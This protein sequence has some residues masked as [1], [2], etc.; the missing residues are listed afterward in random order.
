MQLIASSMHILIAILIFGFL[1]FIHEFGHYAVAKLCD[2]KVDEFSIGMGPKLFGFTKGETLYA[3][4]LVPFG[5]YVKMDGEEDISN[6]ERAFCNKK[7]WQRFLVCIAGV[8]MNVFLGFILVLS[9]VASSDKLTDMTVVKFDDGAVSIKSGLQEGDKILEI[10]NHKLN[11]RKD[12]NYVLMATSNDENINMLVKRNNSLITLR[13]V[14]LPVVQEINGIKIRDFDFEFGS[15]EK[16]V[17]GVL[18]YTCHSIFSDVKSVYI[19]L[20]YL[21]NRTYSLKMMAGPIRITKMVSDASASGLRPLISLTAML[22]MNL[23]ILNLLPFP[24]LDG[25]RALFSFFEM[26]TKKRLKPEWEGYI[27]TAGFVIL[28]LF[29]VYIF[30]N[31]IVSFFN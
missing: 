13:N 10:N 24:G 2:I 21:I 27:H 11:V 3:I 28:M 16:T 18:Q 17:F 9:I 19:S 23:A 29:S 6:N 26:M 30:W 12:L 7:A 22:T 1:I 31:D 14:K 20:K 15:K 4:R 25:C 5:G 8:T